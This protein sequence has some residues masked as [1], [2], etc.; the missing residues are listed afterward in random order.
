MKHLLLALALLAAANTTAQITWQPE[1]WADIKTTDFEALL[2]DLNLELTLP[3]G[4]TE[5]PL[6]ENPHVLYHKAYYHEPSGFEVRIWIKDI[7][8]QPTLEDVTPDQLFKY[9][10]ADVAQAAAGEQTVVSMFAPKAC[11]AKYNADWCGASTF[12]PQSNAFN[13]GFKWCSVVGRRK[14]KLAEVYLFFMHA[15]ETQSQ[16]WPQA[17]SQLVQFK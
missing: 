14:D 7:R 10:L 3:E 8:K 5:A 4:F 9:C 17:L 16:H 2:T 6:V 15:D 1:D 13:R 12:E 11:Q